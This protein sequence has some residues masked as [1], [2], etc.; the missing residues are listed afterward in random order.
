M[1]QCRELTCE[2]NLGAKL[3]TVIHPAASRGQSRGF[4]RAH[5]LHS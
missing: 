5:S 3:D 4:Y 2:S 1:I